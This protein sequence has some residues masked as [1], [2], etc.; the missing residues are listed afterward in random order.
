MNTSGIMDYKVI[1]HPE[2]LG[3]KLSWFDRSSHV[4]HIGSKIKTG[5]DGNGNGHTDQYEEKP[6][7]VRTLIGHCLKVLKSHNSR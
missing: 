3:Q 2:L 4:Q 7:D 5:D 1:G 6:T